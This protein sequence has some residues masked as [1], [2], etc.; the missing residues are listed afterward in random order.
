MHACT[1]LCVCVC[2][3]CIQAFVVTKL[4]LI[5]WIAAY[6]IKKSSNEIRD[7]ILHQKAIKD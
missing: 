4:P 7:D 5:S 3:C 2:V 1:D 6:K